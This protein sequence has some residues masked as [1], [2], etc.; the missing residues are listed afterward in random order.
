MEGSAVSIDSDRSWVPF[1]PS[2]AA[3]AYGVMESTGVTISAGQIIIQTRAYVPGDPRKTIWVNGPQDVAAGYYG[4]C[5]RAI[6]Y[7]TV[8]LVTTSPTAGQMIGPQGS[9][10]WQLAPGYPGFVCIGT[11]SPTGTAI[12]VRKPEVS[13]VKGTCQGNSSGATLTINTVT[14]MTGLAAVPNASATI[15][16][17]NLFGDTTNSSGQK[18][19][20][21]WNDANAQWETMDIT[22][23]CP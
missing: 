14:A 21:I 9:T 20:A 17:Q 13:T 10:S 23:I 12:V 5:T 11:G 8:A 15:T 19:T 7:P 3:P 1:K 16:V 6:D 18:L 2:A 22:A 4:R